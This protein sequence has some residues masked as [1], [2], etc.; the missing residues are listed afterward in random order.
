MTR[1]LTLSRPPAPTSRTRRLHR[2]AALNAPRYKSVVVTAKA[3]S[4]KTTETSRSE[5][6]LPQGK[7]YT[8]LLADRAASISELDARQEQVY[9]EKLELGRPVQWETMFRAMDGTLTGIGAEEANTAMEKGELTLLDVRSPDDGASDIAW[10][11]SGFFIA[12]TMR[13]GVVPG[14][15]NVPLYSLINGMNLYKQIRRIGFS[16]VFGVLNGQELRMEFVQEVQERFPDQ[17][18]PLVVFCDSSKPTMEK[19]IGRDFGIRSRSLQACYYL[20][21][22]GGYTNVRYLEGGFPGWYCNEEL[23]LDEFIN[24]EAQPFAQRNVPK[25]MSILFFLTFVTSI[26]SGLVF[27]PLLF[28]APEGA[29]CEAGFCEVEAVKNLFLHAFDNFTVI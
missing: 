4:T 12:G 3:T 23:P 28:F 24:P 9:R 18:T 25:M 10:M 6:I 16:Y 11:N 19:A 1:M 7:T 8:Q 21:R 20:M 27:I 14:A 2:K 15:V 22:V 29:L 17:S 13:L 5:S 26:K